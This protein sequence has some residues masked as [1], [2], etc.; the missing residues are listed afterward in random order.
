[1]VDIS[2]FNCAE[3]FKGSTGTIYPKSSKNMTKQ[4]KTKTNNAPVPLYSYKTQSH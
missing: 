4:I 2:Y 3:G 1:M